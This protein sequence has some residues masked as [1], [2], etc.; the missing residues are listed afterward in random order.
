LQRLENKIN[1]SDYLEFRLKDGTVKMGY[2]YDLD[3]GF[4]VRDKNDVS[5]FYTS[6]PPSADSVDHGSM[7][8][9]RTWLPKI[10]LRD[11]GYILVKQTGVKI[12]CMPFH[13]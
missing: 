2:L 4:W 10:P 12:S 11:L 1:S 13:N 8:D 7:V 6:T 3:N 9:P 5:L